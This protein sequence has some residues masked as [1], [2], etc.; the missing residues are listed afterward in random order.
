MVSDKRGMDREIRR[1]W[2][3]KRAYRDR[4]SSEGNY[5]R[6]MRILEAQKASAE[7]VDIAIVVRRGC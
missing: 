7:D 3:D 5:A 1:Q 4:A 6:L 2:S